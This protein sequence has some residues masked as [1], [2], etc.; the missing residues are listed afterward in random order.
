MNKK[1]FVGAFLFN[2]LVGSVVAA[3]VGF[4]PVV[5]VLL[6]NML[7]YVLHLVRRANSGMVF[8]D[9]L[10]QEIW[11]SE[12]K[13]DFYPDNSFLS[14]ATDMSSMVN[15][16]AINLA[17]AGADPDVLVDNTAYPIARADAGDTPL[18]LLLKTY[19]TTSTVVRNAVALELAYDQRALYIRKHQKALLKRFGKDALFNYAPQAD[20]THTPV[21]NIAG[22]SA[23]FLDTIIDM[24]NAFAAL[25]D[26]SGNLNLVLNPAHAAAIA[27]EDRLLYKNFE[28]QPG[29]TLFG[30]RIWMHSQCP[31]YVK[32]TS[33]KAAYNATFDPT[34]HAYAS[35]IFDGNEVMK[36]QGSFEFFYKLRDPDE[37]GDVFN[38]QMRGLALPIR[39]K[40]LGAIIK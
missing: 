27:K 24:Q 40:Y 17:E 12:V 20:S 23:S 11:L 38:F 30:F 25:D 5:G 9:G 6:I 21:M 35:I 28:A 39:N 8:F 26:N 2:A 34:V 3:M 10:A 32:N 19:D 31:F 15:N 18:R 4:S 1:Q 29:S 36:A 16:D 22:T 13:E 33:A 14:A 7:G 37:K